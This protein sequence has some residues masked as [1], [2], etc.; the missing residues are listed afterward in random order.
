MFILL[1]E[2]REGKIEKEEERESE[3][4][5]S[6]AG[7]VS[8]MAAMVGVGPI[9]RWESGASFLV[10]HMVSEAQGLSYPPLLSQTITRELSQQR[11]SRD[12]N[13]CPYGM[14]VPASEE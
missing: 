7:S 3:R 4:S 6:C 8:Q 13:L 9:Q 12:T 5:L 2:F 10:S 11:S 14:P 1:T